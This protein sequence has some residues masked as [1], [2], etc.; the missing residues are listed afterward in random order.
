MRLKAA[1]DARL[2]PDLMIVA[3]TD[4]RATEGL[5]AAVERAERYREAGADMIFVEAPQTAAEL[6]EI[7]RRVRAPLLVNLV[8]GGRTP[9]LPNAQLEAL[10]Y[11]VA[12]YPNT[13]TRTFAKAGQSILAALRTAG[14]TDG[15]LGAM[16]SHDELWSLFDNARWRALENRFQFTGGSG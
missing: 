4:A 6:A 9:L 3:R 15:S 16:L 11:R 5:A 13:L 12:I 14:T 1:L 2:D 8:E 7:P 10:G